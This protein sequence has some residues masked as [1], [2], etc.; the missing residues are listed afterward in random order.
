MAKAE[1]LL[2]LKTRKNYWEAVYYKRKSAVLGVRII[3][4]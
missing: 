1:F 2:T 4:I 3:H